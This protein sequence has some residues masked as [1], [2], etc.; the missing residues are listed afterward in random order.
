[1][2]NKQ[3][4]PPTCASFD[5]SSLVSASLS[6]WDCGAAVGTIAFLTCALAF[7]FGLEAPPLPFF[8][9]FFSHILGFRCGDAFSFYNTIKRK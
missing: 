1:M 9:L 8:F 3:D 7:F 5:N 6:P 4:K 2:I